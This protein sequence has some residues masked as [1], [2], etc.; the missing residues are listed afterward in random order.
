MHP[1]FFVGS[2]FASTC[3]V[4]VPED[5]AGRDLLSLLPLPFVPPAS[6]RL[7]FLFFSFSFGLIPPWRGDSYAAAHKTDGLE[8]ALA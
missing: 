6:C 4:C 5:F 2:F 8:I 7:S 3:A 1:D